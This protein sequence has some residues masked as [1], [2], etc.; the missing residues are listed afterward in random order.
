MANLTGPTVV[1][2]HPTSEVATTPYPHVLGDT[3]KSN[4]KE[5]IYLKFTTTVYNGVTVS[6]SID[7]NFTA[8][9]LAEQHQ[10][11]V[12]V[13]VTPASANEAGWVQIWGYHSGAQLASGSSDVTSAMVAIVASSVSSPNVGFNAVA[14]TTID[15]YVIKGMWVQAA[16][17]TATTSGTS[18][19]GAEVPVFMTYPKCNPVVSGVNDPT[20]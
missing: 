16:A 18:H 2:A 11:P 14:R 12:G 20:S 19:T 5:F 17:S 8:A 7:G 4:G 9:P 15:Y 1:A 10:G 3:M 6:I 13:T